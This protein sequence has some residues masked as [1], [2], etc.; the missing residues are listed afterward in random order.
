LYKIKATPEYYILDK[1]N[2]IIA[3]K[4]APDQMLEFIDNYERLKK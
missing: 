3:K 4:L 1:D 2:K